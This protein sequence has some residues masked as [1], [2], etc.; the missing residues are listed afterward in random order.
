MAI[1][2]LFIFSANNLTVGPSGGQAI[3][4]NDTNGNLQGNNNA[5]YFHGAGAGQTIQIDDTDDGTGGDEVFDFDDGNRGRN[6]QL[7]DPVTFTF[8]DRN[9]DEVTRTFGTG[10]RVQSEFIVNFSSGISIVGLR[11]STD[12][13][14]GSL[15]GNPDLVTV[16]YTFVDSNGNPIAPPPNTDLG[17]IVSA[18]SDGT[19]PWVN[20]ICFT[21][22]TMI[23][24]PQGER[25]AGS[26][27][28]GDLVMTLDHG[29][30]PIRWI[31]RQEIDAACLA[32]EPRL[33]PIRIAAGALGQGM[34]VRDLVVSPQHR[35]LV[36]SKIA[37][38]MFDTVEV[39]VAARQLLGLE[40]VD[41]VAHDAAVTY[42]HFMCDLHE[43]VIADGAPAETMHTGAMALETIGA[44][45]LAELTTIF[46]QEALVTRKMARFVPSGAGA[47][48]MVA[49]HVKNS[50]PVIDTPVLAPA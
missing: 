24:T 36:R 17:T 2:S 6:Q 38:R 16:G 10:T 14:T 27:A 48:Q 49:R 32:A 12:N 28:L 31:A 41:V 45:A 26:L 40:G 1:E 4:I 46:G 20:V 3:R 15:T 21:D 42:V 25:A 37:V 18:N 35:I 9:G 13:M 19:V 50:R 47:R 43:I 33:R 5:S 8:D 7:V 34:P 23:A 44:A 39:L 30:Q 11:L 29:P 22:Q